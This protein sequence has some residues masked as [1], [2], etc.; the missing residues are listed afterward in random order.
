MHPDFHLGVEV[1]LQ[2]PDFFPDN[3]TPG[4]KH[5]LLDFL[6]QHLI[7]EMTQETDVGRILILHMHYI[8]DAQKSSKLA[9]GSSVG[10]KGGSVALVEFDGSFFGVLVV[11]VA[12]QTLAQLPSL[13]DGKLLA[14]LLQQID[15]TI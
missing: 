15:Q 2:I 4:K 6:V 14:L 11:P 10:L 1:I 13:L 8:P 7:V 5:F 12:L 9:D 3:S